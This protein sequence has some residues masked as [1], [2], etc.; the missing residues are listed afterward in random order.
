MEPVTVRNSVLTH[1]HI[2]VDFIGA[3]QANPS[4]YDANEVFA[5]A[6]PKLE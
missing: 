2:L 4:R 3:D 5:A 6:R 1:E